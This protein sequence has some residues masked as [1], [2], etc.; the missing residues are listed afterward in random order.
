MSTSGENQKLNRN[1]DERME[2]LTA[3]VHDIVFMSQKLHANMLA[4]RDSQM[5]QLTAKIDKLAESSARNTE[6]IQART[7]NAARLDIKF[8]RHLE[9]MTG[10]LQKQDERK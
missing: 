4:S 8:E 3:I 1:M 9:I 7:E 6:N 2:A 5:Q 10:L